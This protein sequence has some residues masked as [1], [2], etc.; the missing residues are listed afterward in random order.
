LE[1]ELTPDVPFSEITILQDGEISI[2]NEALTWHDDVLMKQL[3][4]YAVGCWMGRYRLDKPGLHI[5]HPDPSD[6]ELSPYMYHGEQFEI[7]DDGIIPIMTNDCGFSDNAS[8]RFSDFIRTVLGEQKH[9]ENLNFVEHK[10]SVSIDR[11]EAILHQGLLE[12]PQE[13]V[14]EPPLST[15][16]SPRRKVPSK[17]WFTCTA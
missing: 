9:V 6:E 4:S 8:I 17:S 1:D 3:I 15:G 5:A 13:D 7:D 16:S 14:P 12:R 10:D 2:E 11:M